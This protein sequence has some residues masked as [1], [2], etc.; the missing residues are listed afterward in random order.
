M[1]SHLCVSQLFSE[2]FYF[3]SGLET[4]PPFLTNQPVSLVILV[5]Y[6]GTFVGSFGL[7]VVI[8][9]FSKASLSWDALYLYRDMFLNRN[10]RP[11]S[12]GKHTQLLQELLHSLR[13]KFCLSN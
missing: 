3:S 8:E 1:D 7:T 5:L 11:K 4:G 13:N 9:H 12:W 2:C 10:H 6:M